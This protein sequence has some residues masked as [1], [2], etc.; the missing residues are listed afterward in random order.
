V[1]FDSE[2]VLVV[3][4]HPDD[5]VLGCGGSV[6]R[7]ADL[8]AEVDV[9]F[10]SDGVSARGSGDSQ[11]ID[12]RSQAAIR[13]AE[14][15]GANRPQ[16]LG[17]PDNRL[18]DVPLLDV[19]QSIEAVLA[20]KR[21]QLIYTHSSADLN[22]DHQLTARAVVTASR[23][24]PGQ[25]V[26]AVL[27]FEV[28]SSSEWNFGAETVAPFNVV[29][30]VAAQLH[31]KIEALEAYATEMREPPHPRSYENV[32]SLARTRGATHGFEAGEAF[33]LVRASVR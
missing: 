33:S 31:R 17:Y 3:A 21:Y 4:A 16:F 24:L 22:I 32:R 29:I 8:G 20:R 6:A 23:P 5:E 11:E 13:A 28:L 19:V 15:L 1:L 2:A 26:S 12:A 7:H 30:D 14:I 25:S 18:D 10:L 27:S 9:L